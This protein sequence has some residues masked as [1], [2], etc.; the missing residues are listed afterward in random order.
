MTRT[1]YILLSILLLAA[2]A[3]SCEKKGGTAKP[4]DPRSINLPQSEVYLTSEASEFDVQVESNFTYK[5]SIDASWAVADGGTPEQPHFRADANPYGADR[6]CKI[7]FTD[8]NDRYYFKEVTVFQ[9]AP[10]VVLTS[11]S[12][13]DKQ[14]TAETK[15]LLANL[16]LIA[17]TGWMFG[18]HD[19]LWYGRYWYNE[20]GRS[21]TKEVCGDYPAVFSV[22]FADI[23]R[24]GADT[25]ENRIRRRVILEARERGEVIMAC[26]HM[27]N[28]KTG[29][30][31]RA[32]V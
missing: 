8:V 16:W 10:E 2:T 5:I 3:V 7:R 20:P 22:D 24:S 29:K 13:V 31:G 17:D 14:A 28:P 21:D 1:K 25:D 9:T 6:S 4:V 26:A 12:I 23:M 32:H 27:D 18:H 19:D 15:A 11:I 30:I